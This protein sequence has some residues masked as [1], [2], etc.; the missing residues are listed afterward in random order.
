MKQCTSNYPTQ[1]E[2]YN[3]QYIE[4]THKQEDSTF[5]LNPYFHYACA[6]HHR[7]DGQSR[8][9]R[10]RNITKVTKVQRAVYNLSYDGET[11]LLLAYGRLQ[12]AK[13]SFFSNH[14]KHFAEWCHTGKTGI[15]MYTFVLW[16]L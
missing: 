4:M 7:L 12:E 8:Q 5:I 9:I 10:R 15:Y 14:S 6:N 13:Y 2:C 16:P 1:N 11:V 3:M